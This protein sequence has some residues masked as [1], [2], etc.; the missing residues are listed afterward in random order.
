MNR[1]IAGKRR[2]CRKSVRK[3]SRRLSK[4]SGRRS[5]C[6]RKSSRKSCRRRSKGKKRCSWVKRRSKG[7]GQHKGYCKRQSGGSNACCLGVES[8][9]PDLVAMFTLCGENQPCL[10]VLDLPEEKLTKPHEM[11]ELLQYS[12]ATSLGCQSA[13]PNPELLSRRD[14]I[15]P[16][17]VGNTL[18][19]SHHEFGGNQ[20]SLQ[21]VTDGLLNTS[22]ELLSIYLNAK[23]SLTNQGDNVILVNDKEPLIE[24]HRYTSHAKCLIPPC[25]FTWH[26]DDF[27]GVSFETY[28]LIYYLYK[29]YSFMGGDFKCA[30]PTGKVTLQSNDSE[31]RPLGKH[32][33]DNEELDVYHINTKSRRVI[34]MR[35]DLWHIPSSVGEQC[36]GCRDSVVVQMART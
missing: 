23:M 22:I 12:P 13:L 32:F 14:T 25:P 8:G 19:K 21:Y 7:K 11:F 30:F 4:V 31:I 15:S 33:E 26:Q 27:G 28:T 36:H 5:G 29:D 9:D 24:S 18:I 16:S 34:L 3:T 20:Q 6:N 17:R 1:Q 35:G 2:L 10:V